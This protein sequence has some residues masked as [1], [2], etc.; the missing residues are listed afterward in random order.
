MRQMKKYALSIKERIER[1]NVMYEYF[2]CDFITTCSLCPLH[3]HFAC[4]RRRDAYHLVC[5]F[6]VWKWPVWLWKFLMWLKPSI[7]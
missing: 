2:H 6:L 5:K 3:G 4:T 1:D 7:F